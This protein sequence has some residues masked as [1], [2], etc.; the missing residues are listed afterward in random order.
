VYSKNVGLEI[1]ALEADGTVRAYIATYRTTPDADGDVIEPGAFTKSL[2]SQP[3]IPMLWQHDTKAPCGHWFA[4]EL[5]DPHGVLA[6]GKFNLATQWGRDAYG[7]IKGGDTDSCSIGY[8]TE[9]AT[10]DRQ[11]VR[12]LEELN[13]K[14]ASWVT[15]AAD[16]AS[17]LVGVKASPSTPT[18]LKYIAQ[19]AAMEAIEKYTF[20]HSPA[21]LAIKQI[22]T[23]AARKGAANHARTV[24]TNQFRARRMQA[25]VATRFPR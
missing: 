9:K 6:T 12:H 10:Y 17:K 8:L 5:K 4:Y 1:K 11:G 14:E 19:R 7:A 16:G 25:Y 20:E 23:V 24:A 13:L 2:A 15:F 21:V 3:R 22:A 18:S